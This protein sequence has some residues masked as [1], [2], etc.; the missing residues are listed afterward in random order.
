MSRFAD[1]WLR[2]PGLAYLLIGATVATFQ[3]LRM[4]TS[5]RLGLAAFAQDDAYYYFRIAQ[6]IALG[7]GSTWDGIHST[8]GYHPLW[9]LMLIPL[10]FILSDR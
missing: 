8:N 7:R 3:V 5:T 1:R 9:L 6:N 4:V 10:Y 2:F